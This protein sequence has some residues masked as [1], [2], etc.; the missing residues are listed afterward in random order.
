M[1]TLEIAIA[2]AGMT[3]I[4]LLT[5]GFFF[6]QRAQLPVPAWLTEGLRYAPLAAMV[7]VVAPEIVMPQG[8]VITTWKDARLYEAAAA[9]AWFFRR[10]DMFGTI[11]A[12]TAVLLVLRLTLSW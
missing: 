6:L 11:V 10:R 2:I 8:H 5:R 9:T 7:A 3:A 12:G 1:T 4:T